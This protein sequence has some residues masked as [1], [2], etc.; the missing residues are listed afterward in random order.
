M[1]TLKTLLAAAAL[2]MMTGALFATDQ[3][4]N[5][6]DAM[7]VSYA[8]TAPSFSKY[9][10]A[11]KDQEE[12]EKLDISYGV[13]TSVFSQY[14]SRGAVT[15]N[16]PVFQFE[17]WVTIGPL[18]LDI[19]HNMDLTNDVFSAGEITEADYTIEY[20]FS[21]PKVDCALGYVYYTF[22][23]WHVDDTQE[24][25]GTATVDC[26]LS[27]AVE[28]YWDLDEIG[29]IYATGGISHSLELPATVGD[30]K[31]ALDLYATVGYGDSSYIIGAFA[32]TG[33]AWVDL[34]LTAE[35]PID[36]GNGLSLTPSLSFQQVLDSDVRA[37]GNDSDT[38]FAGLT[39]TKE[40]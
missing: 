22:P 31:L 17:G 2:V 34:L 24:V 3:A 4:V 25:Y 11:P 30:E 36:L 10:T 35:V 6:E 21:L 28:L 18:T 23:R 14:A 9:T 38:I 13:S 40:F 5:A 1:K 8:V 39:L 37:A 33:S 29:G 12:A 27:P 16:E 7:E 19:W 20:A 32:L 26:F 15:S